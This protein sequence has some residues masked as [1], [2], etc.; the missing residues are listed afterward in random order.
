MIISADVPVCFRTV[1]DLHPKTILRCK[2]TFCVAFMREGVDVVQR[3]CRPSANWLVGCAVL[4][5]LFYFF[6]NFI[7]GVSCPEN[8][9]DFALARIRWSL[10]AWFA[11]SKN[12]IAN[13]VREKMSSVLSVQW[14]ISTTALDFSEV[15]FC[16]LRL[17][18]ATASFLLGALFVWLGISAIISLRLPNQYPLLSRTLQYTSNC[19]LLHSIP[20]SFASLVRH[21]IRQNISFL[22]IRLIQSINDNKFRLWST[23]SWC[24]QYI[25]FLALSDW[26]KG[27][28]FFDVIEV[29]LFVEILLACWKI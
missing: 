28:L 7:T 8:V 24:D 17:I 15:R 1:Y 3:L 22:L 29:W 11:L 19:S 27:R 20:S 10:L 18:R 25:A 26:L 9:F 16:S 2:L 21:V 4:F 13:F 5:V 14:Y 23:L 12:V 6:K